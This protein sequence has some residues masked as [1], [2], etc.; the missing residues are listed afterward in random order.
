MRSGKYRE[1]NYVNSWEADGDGNERS[2]KEL[3]VQIKLLG[4]VLFVFWKQTRS[5]KKQLMHNVPFAL[6]IFLKTG[7]LPHFLWTR[8]AEGVC[9]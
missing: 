7:S 9:H 2:D 4:I 6:S 1:R 5:L 8:L 3:W